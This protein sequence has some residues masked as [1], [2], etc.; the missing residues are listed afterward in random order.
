[1]LPKNPL[2]SDKLADRATSHNPKVYD[3]NLD[4]VELEDWIR[5][6]EKIFTVI[7]VPKEKK[8]NI[9]TFYLTGEAYI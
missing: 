3:E 8:V 2:K 6:M 4:L 7:E 9:W 5:G 1:M